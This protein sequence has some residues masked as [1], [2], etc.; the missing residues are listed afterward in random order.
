MDAPRRCALMGRLRTTPHMKILPNARGV[1]RDLTTF[2]LSDAL[3]SP[4][5]PPT[6]QQHFCIVL[7]DARA[8]LA[9]D[10]IET[11]RHA[12]AHRD[13]AFMRM[14]NGNLAIAHHLTDRTLPGSD[15]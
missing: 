8:R 14:P 6:L 12:L 5:L 15:L 13:I 1:M 11:S 3:Q 2:F 10:F 4:D 7:V 9:V